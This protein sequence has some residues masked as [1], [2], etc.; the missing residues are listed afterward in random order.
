[1]HSI[2]G[3]EINSYLELTVGEKMDITLI[4]LDNPFWRVE[5]ARIPL[6]IGGISF[7]DKRISLEEF[8]LPKKVAF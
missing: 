6:F 2:N 4:Y 3:S 8:V 7:G 1:M 5:L